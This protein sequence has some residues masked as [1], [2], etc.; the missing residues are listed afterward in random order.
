MMLGV[1]PSAEPTSDR[2]LAEPP[3]AEPKPKRKREVRGIIK[4][5]VDGEEYKVEMR[6]SGITVRRCKKHHTDTKTMR[7]IVD[8]VV[9]QE[10]LPLD[11]A[12][13]KDF[14]EANRKADEDAAYRAKCAEHSE[15][16]LESGATA[17]P[18]SRKAVT[19]KASLTVCT[20][21]MFDAR[22]QITHELR[23]IADMVEQ[24]DTF[25]ESGNMGACDY[26]SWSISDPW[27]AIENAKT[28][29]TSDLLESCIEFIALQIAEAN[30][31][32]KHT[33]RYRLAASALR[34]QVETLA[35][36][37]IDEMVQSL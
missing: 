3:A 10:R 17:L 25:S 29:P 12:P 35:K 27:E 1:P 4:T 30:N 19:L 9:G 26:G 23:R 14:S 33:G 20:F 31:P 16:S 13:V 11:V 6:E 21:G 32:G 18:V 37:K 2:S 15:P 24:G 7:E 36:G 22:E 34:E 28:D 8:F 5:D